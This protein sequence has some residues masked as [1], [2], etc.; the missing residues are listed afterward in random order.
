MNQDYHDLPFAVTRIDTHYL[1]PEMTAAYLLVEKGCAAFIETGPLLAVPRL[2]GALDRAGLD[3]NAVKAIIVTHVHLD[4]AG[5]AGELMR[6]CPQAKLYVHPLGAP[7]L[8]DPTRLKASAI[9]VYGEKGFKESLGDIVATPESRVVTPVDG[10]TVE[11]GGRTLT[12]FDTPGHARHHFSVWDETS[13]GI[14]TGDVFG[15]SYRDFDGGDL[16]FIF[17]AT[18]P[19]QLDPAAFHLSMD[20][21]A[22]LKPD[23]LYLTHFDAIPYQ[24]ALLKSLHEQ[25]DHYL[26]LAKKNR[27]QGVSDHQQLSSDLEE[28]MCDMLEKIHAPNPDLARSLLGPDRE[29]NAQGLEI[30]L[31]RSEKHEKQ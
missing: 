1:R 4:H 25:L 10:D 31:E 8:I 12:F 26:V 22:A 13:R 27:N 19:T 18:T 29:I 20:R 16:P 6:L 17:P 23:T 21:L 28:Y 30:W 9:L 15:L 11:I 3:E 7:H 14:F 5:G 2:M 24:P